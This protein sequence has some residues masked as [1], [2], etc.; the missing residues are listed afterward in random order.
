MR[1]LVFAP[2]RLLTILAHCFVSCRWR[3]AG[4][5]TLL[6]LAAFGASAQDTAA[7]DA[8]YE[9]LLQTYYQHPD[10][11]VVAL[12]IAYLNRHSVDSTQKAAL[13]SQGQVFVGFL[14]ALTAQDT[15]MRT[16]LRARLSQINDPGFRQLVGSLLPLTPARLFA[17]L[18]LTPS[19]NDMAWAAYFATG[20]PQY[21][22]LLVRNCR[23]AVERKNLTLY[24]T[25]AS[26]RWS[27]CAMAQQDSLVQQYLLR[28]RTSKEIQLI[29][30]SNP[31]AL[32][33]QMTEVLAQNQQRGGWRP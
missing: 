8:Y 10:K 21:L 2:L 28:Q 27:L 22:D 1:Q 16:Q 14:T 17:N 3:H 30:H 19:Y 15:A 26:A 9:R 29:L 31:S 33:Q 11:Q 25:G 6:C 24:V 4:L 23:Y 12:T 7:A 18:P 32:R 20:A 5:A 13:Q